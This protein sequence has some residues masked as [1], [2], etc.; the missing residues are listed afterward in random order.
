MRV[1]EQMITVT[2]GFRNVAV[3]QNDCL[4]ELVPLIYI[5]KSVNINVFSQIA[6]TYIAFNARVLFFQRS[7]SSYC[8]STHPEL[9][10]L[11]ER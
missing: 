2:M 6:L 8:E 3:M 5:V 7:P 10:A 4:K 1:T 9:D 11:N